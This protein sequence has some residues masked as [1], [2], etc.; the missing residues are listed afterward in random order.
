MNGGGGGGRSC[1]L[2]GCVSVVAS[3][4]VAAHQFRVAKLTDPTAAQMAHREVIARHY[5]VSWRVFAKVC[6]RSK[7]T[8][9]F[10]CIAAQWQT[11]THPARR[12]RQKCLF[13]TTQR[14]PEIWQR[15][16][17]QTLDCQ[18]ML[19]YLFIVFFLIGAVWLCQQHTLTHT[20]VSAQTEKAFKASPLNSCPTI[21]SS[22]EVTVWVS[23]TP[24]CR[25]GRLGLVMHI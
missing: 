1:C 8:G 14:E 17:T 10:V 15:L 6:P 9:L 12:D 19:P 13:S 2:L 22:P 4:A 20:W 16:S 3:P 11:L 7:F 21:T 18:E 5:R 23:L 25:R 24:G